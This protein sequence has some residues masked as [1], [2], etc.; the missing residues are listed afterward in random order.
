MTAIPTNS[1]GF[2]CRNSPNSGT[3]MMY[4]AVKKPL[5]A[6][7]GAPAGY[8]AMP[9]CCRLTE[10]HSIT[11]QIT[12]ALMSFFLSAGFSSSSGFPLR[13]LVTAATGISAADAISERIAFT[14]N[15]GIVSLSFSCA[16]KASPHM[17][18]A[19]SSK[20]DDST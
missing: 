5:C 17:I 2:L 7:A 12:P 16:T 6:D 11:P 13:R 3:K 19:V 18:A 15:G 8:S 1:P 10:M 9:N 14:V 4:S 20:T